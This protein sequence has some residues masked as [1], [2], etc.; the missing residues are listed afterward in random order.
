MIWAIKELMAL[1]AKGQ[2]LHWS[3]LFSRTT[4]DDP[5]SMGVVWVMFLVDIF[6]YA[7]VVWYIDNVAPGK[8]GVAKKFYFPFQAKYWCGVR[9]SVIPE[10]SKKEDQH[11][12]NELFEEEPQGEAGIRVKD[13]KKDFKSFGSKKQVFAVNGVSFSAFKGEITT[14]LGH[15]GAG[16]TTTM[17]VLTGLYSPS[18][19]SAELNGYNINEDMDKVRES[20]GLCP[21]HNMLFEDLTVR[22]HLVFFAML[23][24]LSKSAAEAEA[25]NYINMLNLVAKTNVIVTNLSGG[26]KR[27][28]NLGIALIGDSK[29]LMLDEPTSGMDPEAR[30]GMWDLLM[31]LK[32]D[33]TMLLTTHFM[34]EADVLGDRIAIMAKGQVKCYGTPF[35]L[36]R[37][38]GSG[39][40]LVLTKSK[41]EADQMTRIEAMIQSHVPAA[42]LKNQE[43]SDIVFHLPVDD[44]PKFPDMFQSLETAKDQLGISSF[45]LSLTT[46]EDVFLKVG[47][48]ATEETNGHLPASESVASNLDIENMSTGSLVKDLLDG[49]GLV[50]SQM[51]GLLVK[52]MVYTWRRKLLYLVMMVIPIAMALLTVLSTNPGKSTDIT[53]PYLDITL[54]SYNEP[55]SFLGF[56]DN[57]TCSTC[58]G[59]KE[60]FERSVK[61]GTIKGVDAGSNLSDT[62]LDMSS[63]EDLSDYRDHYIIAG[64]FKALTEIKMFDHSLTVDMT[65]LI[66]MF[67]TVPLH[68][69]PLAQ[70]HISNALLGYLERENKTKHSISIASHPMPQPKKFRFDMVSD[71]GVSPIVFGFGISFPIGL[72]ILVSAF[73][74]FPLVERATNAKQVQIMAGVH[75]GTFWISNL[76]WDLFLYFLSAFVMLVLILLLDDREIFLTNYAWGAFIVI[77]IL[78]GMFGT[79][80]S[81]VF[82]FLADSSA[83]GFASLIVLN[84]LAGTIAPTGVIILRQLGSTSDTLLMVSDIVRWLFNWFPIF[85]FTRALMAIISVQES[86]N[87]CSSGIELDTLINI[88]Q[89]FKEKPMTMAMNPGYIKCCIGDVVGEENQVCDTDVSFNGHLIFNATDIPCHKMESFF[90]FDPLKGINLDVIMLFVDGLIYFLILVMIEAKFVARLRVMIQGILPGYYR[91]KNKIDDAVDDDVEAEQLRINNNREPGA[92]DDVLQVSHLQ[93]KFRGL[94]AVNNMSFG[95]KNGECFGLLG[96]NGAGKT[97]TFRMLTGDE[98]PTKGSASLLGI[99]LG[100]NRRKYLSKI[101]YCP[102]FD[103]IIPQLTGKELLTLMARIRGVRSGRL[104]E[105][106]ARWTNFLGIQE[107][108]QRE[109]GDYSGGNKRKLNV[110]MSLVGEPPVVFLDEPSTGVDPV[111]RRNLWNIIQNIQKNGQSVILTSHSMDECEALCDRMGIMVNGQ[112]KCFGTVQHLKKKF[113][114]GFT[115][116]TKLKQPGAVKGV[117]DLSEVSVNSLVEEDLQAQ[118]LKEHLKTNLDDVSVKDEHKGYIHFHVGN[119]YTPWHRLFRVMETAK[120]NMEFLEDYTVSETTLEQVFLSFA[121]QQIQDT[122]P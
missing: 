8:F 4:P 89:T 33:R 55:V 108:I 107:Y 96:I 95:V 22:E 117:K 69:R 42:E 44:S 116:L 80:F 29:I 36:K 47:E 37:R 97:T 61:S 70:N 75:A 31:S 92:K 120:Q 100:G 16:K 111:A 83:S 94:Q 26:M 115:I 105:E 63:G 110:A 41:E 30:R 59:L 90:T 54:S 34:E 60:A 7:I 74:I 81:Y 19:G 119:P 48:M 114:Q 58:Y 67:N 122:A 72:A 38:F 32:K 11:M 56:D 62:I 49:W 91:I 121:K 103:S 79:L 28:V 109:S 77:I 101:G 82:S 14:L 15:N 73:L 66:G 53:H 23:K 18:S 88:C 113:A 2:G 99:S 5:M 76:I 112:F 98:V 65:E 13:L 51:K 9:G 87:L 68:S 6:V 1:E 86:N 3:S 40:K 50:W 84:I 39:Y 64:N 85:P 25:L 102:Q 21:Q 24:G 45:G 104:E 78:L 93:K 52:R 118:K 12:Y 106:V 17:S 10:Q 71:G 43:G 20:L 46:M 57:E 27:K 35:F